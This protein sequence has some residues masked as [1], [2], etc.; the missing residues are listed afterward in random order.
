MWESLWIAW[1]PICRLDTGEVV[2]HEALIRGPRG[3]SLES[4]G[5]LFAWATRQ[6]MAQPFEA[7]CR[8]LA[9]ERASLVLPVTQQIFLNVNLAWPALELPDTSWPPSQVA[10][11]ISERNAL[12]EDVAMRD[13]TIEWRQRGHPLVVDDYGAGFANFE[14]ILA[15]QPHMLKLDRLLIAGIDQDVQRQSMVRAT[16]QMAQDLHL[17][18][19]AEGIETRAELAALQKLGVPWGQGFLLGRPAAEPNTRGLVEL[20]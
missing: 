16:M 15:L 12:A 6:G 20:F 14:Q 4:P 1:Q 18:V 19:I 10:L 9:L 2:G 8:H 13:K 3:S 5:A 17:I 7:Y 11:E